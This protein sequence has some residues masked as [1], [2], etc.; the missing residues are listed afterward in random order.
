MLLLQKNHPHGQK[1]HEIIDHPVISYYYPREGAS[2]AGLFDVFGFG[3]DLA[4]NP[5]NIEPVLDN[6]ESRLP[7]LFFGGEAIPSFFPNYGPG[8]MAAVFGVIPK[9]QTRTMWFSRPTP[10]DEIVALLEN[11]KLNADNQWYS[12]SG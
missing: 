6:F 7:D 8:I 2:V 10:V 5:D 1:D 9:Y 12:I 11:V 3:W 4:K